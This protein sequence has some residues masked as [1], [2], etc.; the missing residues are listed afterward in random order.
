[1]T[2][3]IDIKTYVFLKNISLLGFHALKKEPVCSSK[4]LDSLQITQHYT[5]EDHRCKKGKAIP[6]TGREGP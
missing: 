6:V 2:F 1:M 3:P 5:A 4:M